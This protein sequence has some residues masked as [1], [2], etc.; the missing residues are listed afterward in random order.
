M[1]GS[2]SVSEKV[3]AHIA[4]LP[5]SGIRKFFDLVNSMDD[6]ISLGVGEPD[7]TTPWTIREGSIYSLERGHTSYTSNLGLLSLRKAICDLYARRYD[8]HLD[9]ETQ[10]IAT[11]GSKEGLAHLCL[12]MLNPGDVVFAPDPTY[13][14]HVYAPVICGAD[15]RRIPVAE[16]RDFF[17]DLL[18]ATKQ[19]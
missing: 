4:S 16:D 2:K 15:V 11:I 18:T 19:T 3:A 8:V 9:P 14:I 10:A 13:P 17:E 5:K 7:F 1:N 6:V 12:A